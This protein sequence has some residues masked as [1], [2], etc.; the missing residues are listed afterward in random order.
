M[1]TQFLRAI[2]EGLAPSGLSLTLLSGEEAAG[3]VP[4]RDVPMDGALVFDCDPRSPALGWLRRRRLPMVFI[5]QDPAPGVPCINVDDRGGAFAA[6][7]SRRICGD[8]P[9][10]GGRLAPCRLGRIW[11]GVDVA[12][13]VLSWWRRQR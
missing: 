12:V 11:V 6:A 1:A 3:R 13:G 2:L 10:V 9:V 5:D 7:A 8:C 4:A